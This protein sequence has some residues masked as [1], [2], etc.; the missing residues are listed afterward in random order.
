VHADEAFRCIVELTVEA[1]EGACVT[2]QGR[3]AD[4]LEGAARGLAAVDLY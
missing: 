3:G 2:V 1:T 4:P